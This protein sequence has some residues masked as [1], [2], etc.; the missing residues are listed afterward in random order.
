[1]RYLSLLKNQIKLDKEVEIQKEMLFSHSAFNTIEAFKFLDKEEKGYITADDISNAFDGNI[2]NS[3]EK[4]LI[5]YDK[6]RDGVLNFSEFLKAVTPKNTHYHNDA[7][8][9]HFLNPELKDAL[10]KEWQED[11]REVLMTATRAEEILQE[12]RDSLELNGEEVFNL[13]DKIGLGYITSRTL[14]NWLREEVGFNVNQLENDLIIARYDK[15][16]DYKIKKE[17]FIEEVNAIN[18]EEEENLEN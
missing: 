2:I 8:A 7:Y 11:L 15:D 9:R 3:V 5:R 18:N 16:Q 17:E 14:A 10:N 4:L 1:L 13:I 12:I 6:D